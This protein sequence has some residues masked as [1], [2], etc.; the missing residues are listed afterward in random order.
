MLQP[1]SL[2]NYKNLLFPEPF[3]HTPLNVLIGFIGSGKSILMK[4]PSGGGPQNLDNMLSS[5]SAYKRSRL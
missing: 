5:K 3:V 2:Q 1:L 4:M